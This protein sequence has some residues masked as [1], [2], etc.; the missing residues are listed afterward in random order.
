L[1]I[2]DS[3]VEYSYAVYKNGDSIKASNYLLDILNVAHIR[4]DLE[5]LLRVHK[6]LYFLWEEYGDLNQAKENL[7]LYKDIAGMKNNS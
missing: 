5:V 3:L 7:K 4:N 6:L 1:N 2:I